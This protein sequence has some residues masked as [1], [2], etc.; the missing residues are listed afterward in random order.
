MEL[1]ID[2]NIK[3][4]L[5][6]ES[7]SQ[8][9]FEIADAN[10]TYL[11]EWLVWVDEMKSVAFIE[12]YIKGSAQRNRDGNEFA[13]VIFKNKKVVGRIGIYKI[14]SINKIGEIGYWIIENQQGYGIVTKCCKGL[15]NFCFNQ[16]KLNRI[17]IICGTEN[18]KS[19]I[20]PKQLGFFKEGIIRQG[21]LVNNT[22]I[23]LCLFSLLKTD[24][25]N[26]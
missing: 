24:K 26:S 5:I 14:N 8:A 1:T 7:H 25:T 18:Y 9:V 6:N 17:E 22:F 16:L 10:R 23:D 2:E 20:I 4:E 11:R 21:A 3:L 15:I 13:F 12:N 19:Q